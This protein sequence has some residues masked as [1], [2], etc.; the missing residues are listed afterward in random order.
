MISYLQCLTWTFVPG[1]LVGRKHHVAACT[2]LMVA[3]PLIHDIIF[4]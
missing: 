3:T 2:E 4:L 1:I